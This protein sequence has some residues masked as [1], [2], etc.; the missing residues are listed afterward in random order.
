MAKRKSRPVL[1][2]TKPKEKLAAAFD[3][4]FCGHCRCVDAKLEKKRALGTLACRICSAS[5][6]MRVSPL[7][8]PIDLFS[9]WIDRCEEENKDVNKNKSASQRRD[10]SSVAQ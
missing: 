3:C 10:D 1:R 7:T 2:S 5:Y 9:D 4:P 8:E 6:S